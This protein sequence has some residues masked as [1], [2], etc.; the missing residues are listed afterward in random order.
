VYTI[1]MGRRVGYVGGR[2]GAAAGNPAANHIQLVVENG[3]Q[4]ISAY[5]IIP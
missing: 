2:A 1:D 4:V 3:N 5:P